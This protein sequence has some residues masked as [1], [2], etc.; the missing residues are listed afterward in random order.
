MEGNKQ[1]INQV[2]K[3]CS[4]S[5]GGKESKGEKEGHVEIEGKSH[6]NKDTKEKRREHHSRLCFVFWWPMEA[7]HQCRW[8]RNCKGRG[9]E[10]ASSKSGMEA[11]VAGK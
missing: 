1:E 3:I 8:E 7:S 9:H 5:D 11:N 10:T 4:M 6:S 2:I